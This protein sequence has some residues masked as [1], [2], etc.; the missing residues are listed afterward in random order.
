MKK[1]YFSS[2]NFGKEDFL[3]LYDYKYLI[4]PRLI[5]IALAVFAVASPLIKGIAFISIFVFLT[6]FFIF[7]LVLFKSLNKKL[8]KQIANNLKNKQFIPFEITFNEDSFVIVYD[9]KE[10]TI[11]YIKITSIEENE[12]F[13][14][15]YLNDE[16]YK[17]LPVKKGLGDFID[18][19][20]FFEFI[21][22]KA[23]LKNRP[24]KAVKN[25]RQKAQVYI[26]YAGFAAFCSLLPL[27]YQFAHAFY[28]YGSLGIR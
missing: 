5:L 1:P 25:R 27:I 19:S 11:D 8:D 14:T 28:G 12:Y 22:K 23:K 4:F 6:A 17:E 9:H 24:I 26:I 13:Y 7:A 18:D 16:N 21:F 10:T 2:L 20:D 3:L 15:L